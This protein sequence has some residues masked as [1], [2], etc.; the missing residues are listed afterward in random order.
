MSVPL[1]KRV[2]PALSH[3]ASR[4]DENLSLEVLAARARLSPFYLHRMFV[5]VARETPK[6]YTLRLRLSQ[7]AAMLL[8][9]DRSV[10]AIALSAGFQSHEVF[11][12]AFRKQFGM[13]PRDYRARG[14]AVAPAAGGAAAHAALVK[15]VGPCVRLFHMPSNE[16]LTRR[17]MTYNII[18]K[19]LD[20]QPVLVAR[21]R[22]KRSE[23]A[24]TIGESLGHIFQ[25]AQANGIALTGHPIT[26]YVE[27]G[28]GLLTIEPGMRIVSRQSPAAGAVADSELAGGGVAELAL[29]AGPVATTI[30]AGPYDTL[31]EAYAALESWIESNGLRSAGPPWEDYI[32]DPTEFADP[33]DWKTEVCWPVAPRT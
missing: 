32:T 16:P 12:R 8:T 27:V 10:L 19:D 1:F 3:A 11:T 4:L 23:I 31:P 25:Y 14:F 26:R 29:P 2:Q 30:H 28:P 6:A 15:R 7:A 5:A 20:S 18:K 13:T 22:V 9:S 24:A 21:R 33:K 17:A